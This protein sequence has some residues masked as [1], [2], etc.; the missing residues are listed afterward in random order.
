MDS[1]HATITTRW[2]Y[3][4]D[5]PGFGPPD[6]RLVIIHQ[7]RPRSWVTCWALNLLEIR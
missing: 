5:G 6:L 4:P 7:I 1:V 3:S 2:D